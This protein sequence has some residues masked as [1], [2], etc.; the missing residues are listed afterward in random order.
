[1]SA[2][3]P[4]RQR[5]VG[6]V[7]WL[8]CAFAAGVLLERSGRLLAPFHYPPAGVEKTFA[9]FWETWAKARG[10]ETTEVLP[11]VRAVLGR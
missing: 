3:V 6:F 1:M 7:F 8:V 4:F 10:A 11:K 5:P 9:P 2:Q